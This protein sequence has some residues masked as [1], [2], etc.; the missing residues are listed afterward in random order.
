[1]QTLAQLG[2]AIGL[3]V[4]LWLFYVGLILLPD[5]LRRKR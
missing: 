5:Y 4:V 3:V 1:M 2:A